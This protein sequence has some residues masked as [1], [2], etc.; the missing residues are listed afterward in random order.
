MKIFSRRK[1]RGGINNVSLEKIFHRISSWSITDWCNSI[2]TDMLIRSVDTRDVQKMS[3]VDDER[4]KSKNSQR[5]RILLLDQTEEDF[6]LNKDD[7]GKIFYTR[8]CDFLRLE[9]KDYF[10]LMFI[11]HENIKVSVYFFFSNEHVIREKHKQ[12]EMFF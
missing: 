7:T 3:S 1:Q 4:M 9:E 12:R 5:V 11:N 8:V 6:D 10:G 2:L